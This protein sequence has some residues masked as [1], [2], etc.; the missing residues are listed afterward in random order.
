MRRI[1]V[2][3]CSGAGKTRLARQLAA[4]LDVPHIEL[5]AIY[6][7]P[8]WRPLDN[9]RFQAELSARMRASPDGW[10]TCGNYAAQTG[11]RHVANADTLVWVDPPR[12]VVMWRVVTRTIRRALV[13]EELWN[14]NRE[15]LRNL[16]RWDPEHN[17]IRWAWITWPRYRERYT[18][19][20]RDGTWDHVDVHRLTTTAQVHAF[21]A[22]AAAQRTATG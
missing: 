22:R 10:V 20:V 17:I 9:Q 16:V 7:Q 2:V 14:G 11:N 19:R 13:R 8:G 6:H 15:R 18:R 1:V 12:R 5:D 3:G 4:A 21:V